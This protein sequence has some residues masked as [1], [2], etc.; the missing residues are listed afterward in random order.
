VSVT[1]RGLI[2]QSTRSTPGK[3]GEIENGG[4]QTPRYDS[5]HGES[6]KGMAMSMRP[7]AIGG[8]ALLMLLGPSPGGFAFAQEVEDVLPC[9]TCHEQ[10]EAFVANPHAR[11]TLV[12]GEVPGAVCESCH[13]DGSEHI[14]AGGDTE[15]IMLPNGR[16]GADMCLDCHDLTN[17]HQSRR[18][19]FHANSDAV[20]C[21]SCHSVHSSAKL[22]THLLAKNQTELCGTC[23]G[24][25]AASFRNKPYAHRIGRGGMECSSCHNPH[26]RTGESLG[27]TRAGEPACLECHI[28]RRGP[29][30]FPHASVEIGG[31][32]QCHELHGSSNPKQLKR[33]DVYQVCIECH[34][35]LGGDGIGSQ[36]PAFHNLTQ[37]RFRN[38]T[39]CHTAIHGSNRSPALLK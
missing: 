2:G 36:P 15:K 33:S 19:G 27:S 3:Q 6:R 30:V 13:G 22:A 11:G 37:A 17:E 38:C 32:T 18:N 26:G 16:A 34:S 35:P 39:T 21:L 10:P 24:T 8:I 5:T 28:E 23:H 25:Q 31:C 4:S 14:E 1:A 20:N 29:Y 9:S 7:I 12:D